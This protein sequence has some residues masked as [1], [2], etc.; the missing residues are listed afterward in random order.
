MKRSSRPGASRGFS[1][2]ELMI[3]LVLGLLV[4]GSALAIFLSN[5]QTYSATEGVGRAQENVRLAFELMSRDLRESGSTPCGNSVRTVSNVLNNPGTHWYDWQNA[6]TGYD[7]ATALGTI[8]FGTAKGNRIAGTAAVEVH[9]GTADGQKIASHNDAA[10]TF[11]MVSANHGFVAG[12]IVVACDYKRGA[13]FQVTG[14]AGKVLTY[15]AGAG[16][17]GNSS[18]D[19]GGCLETECTPGK[20]QF[21]N[22]AI[23]TRLGAS[24]WYIGANGRTCAGVPCRSLYQQTVQSGAGSVAEEIAENVQDLQLSYLLNT[25][26]QFYQN[27]LVTPAASYAAA[28]AAGAWD[29]VLAIRVAMRFTAPEQV[30]GQDITRT[31]THVVTVRNQTI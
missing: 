2:V 28:I 21:Q 1:I 12:D 30:N 6:A 24:R 26:A 14:V 8:P 27:R 10:G 13:V 15:A 17:P 7:G 3:A 16:A 20:Y 22:T 11:T 18:I 9:S 29:R 25:N 23:I 31:L 5:R 19:L 4:V